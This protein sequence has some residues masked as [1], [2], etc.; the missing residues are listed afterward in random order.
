MW[1]YCESLHHSA[2]LHLKSVSAEEEVSRRHTI[3]KK[4]TG[5]NYDELDHPVVPW[6]QQCDGQDFGC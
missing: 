3:I 2:L 1:C 4:E 6:Q 5:S